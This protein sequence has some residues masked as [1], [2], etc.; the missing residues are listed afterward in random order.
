MLRLFTR[1]AV[2]CDHTMLQDAHALRG[3]HE[4]FGLQVDFYFFVQKRQIFDFLPNRATMPIRLSFAT[5][6]VKRQ[7]ICT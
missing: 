3:M 2:V 4:A 5:V 1:V 7:R 6:L